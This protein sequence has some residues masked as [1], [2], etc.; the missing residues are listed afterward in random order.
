LSPE[1][2]CYRHRPAIGRSS[3]PDFWNSNV[4]RWTSVAGTALA[5]RLGVPGDYVHVSPVQILEQPDSI[6]QV[7]PMRNRANN[8]GLAADEEISTEFL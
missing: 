6:R 1:P 7:M 8:G 3:S 4:E 5:K 2:S